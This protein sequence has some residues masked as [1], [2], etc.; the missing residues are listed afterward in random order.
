MRV[1]AHDGR[2]YDV[3][4]S[5]AD[6]PFWL[7][8]SQSHNDGWEAEL[9]DGTSLGTPTVVNGMANGWLI[10]PKGA[11]DIVVHVRWTPQTRVWIGLAVTALGVLLCLVLALRRRRAWRG[12]TDARAPA[13]NVRAWLDRDR[14]RPSRALLALVPVGLGIVGALVSEPWVGLV[15]ALG[16]VGALLDRRAR[17]V[18]RWGAVGALVAA[19]AFV[20]GQQLVQGYP[21]AYDWP[22]RFLRVDALPWLALLL[23]TASVVV[24][25]VLDPPAETDAQDDVG[26]PQPGS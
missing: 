6:E 13:P 15:V 4:V 26:V 10:D 23:L 18:V 9:G 21:A 17:A 8:L 22:Q 16:T 1:D 20:V 11:G 24:D 12:R 19:A 7:V 14:P 5:G 25:R 3:R 2:S